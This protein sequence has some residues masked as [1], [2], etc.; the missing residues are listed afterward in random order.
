M[1]IKE[2]LYLAYYLCRDRAMYHNIRQY[3]HNQYA[4]P[5]VYKDIQLSMLNNLIKHAYETVPYYKRL[6]SSI[7]STC[8]PISI[9]CLAQLPILTKRDLRDSYD[10]LCSQAV[11]PGR[12][13]KNS[14][15]GTTGTST[16]FLSDSNAN[17]AKGAYGFI[18]YDMMGVPNLAKTLTIWAARFDVKK[19]ASVA[20]RIID[21]IKSKRMVYADLSDNGI[22]SLIAE[23]NQYKPVVLSSYPSTLEFMAK[24]KHIVKLRHYPQA[25]IMS[26]EKLYDHQRLLINEAFHSECFDYYGARDGSTIAQE[27]SAHNGMHLFGHSVLLEVVDDNNQPIKDGVGRVLITDLHNYVMPLIRYEIGDLAEVSPDYE[28]PCVCGRLTPR[29]KQIISRAFDIVRFPNG[30]AVV[31]TFWTLL[32][33]SVHGIQKFKV[34]QRSDA[35]IDIYYVKDRNFCDA[36]LQKI[37][38]KLIDEGG[39]ELVLRFHEQLEI[40]SHPRSGKYRFVESEYKL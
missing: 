35:S 22:A 21:T 39:L 8:Y 30:K 27:C 10:E 13:V 18:Q 31:G 32:M 34:I 17:S 25:I 40:A 5:K 26:G 38:S 12:F 4:S 9:D 15:S 16:Y 20:R 36:N 37:R 28:K 14:T 29:I 7:D 1:P 19:E 11:D 23:I 33:R 2:H 3:R 24:S 6:L